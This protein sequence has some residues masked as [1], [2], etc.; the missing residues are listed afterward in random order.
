MRWI[1]DVPSP[2]SS[3][4]RVAVEALDLLLLGVAVAAVNAEAAL[5]DLVAG[6]GDEQPR[7]PALEVGALADILP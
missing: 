5:D 1:S 6:L 3:S 2:I 7:H 4:R